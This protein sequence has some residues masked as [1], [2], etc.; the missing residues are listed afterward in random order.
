MSPIALPSAPPDRE[1]RGPYGDHG[2]IGAF[3]GPHQ[4]EQGVSRLQDFPVGG[5]IQCSLAVA[6]WQVQIGLADQLGGMLVA[7][8]LGV[9]LVSAKDPEFGV[10]QV[11]MVGSVPQHV[12]QQSGRGDVGPAGQR[13]S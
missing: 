11:D 12:V 5:L 8:G 10:F 2:A 13:S 7:G 9:G 1:S 3:L 4:V 6:P